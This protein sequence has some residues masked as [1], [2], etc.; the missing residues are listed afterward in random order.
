MADPIDTEALLATVAARLLQVGH[1]E[2]ALAIADGDVE[3]MR[4]YNEGTHVEIGLRVGGAHFDALRASELNEGHWYRD[5]NDHD[6]YDPSVLEGAFIAALPSRVTGVTIIAKMRNVPVDDD[7]RSEFANLVRS[8]PRNQGTVPGVPPAG[9]VGADGLRYR[10]KTEIRLADELL[11][12]GILYMPLGVVARR[13]KGR[14]ERNEPDF[15]IFHG[16]RTGVLEV[17]GAPFH[18]PARAVE[19]EARALPFKLQGVRH[20]MFDSELVYNHPG[21]VIDTFLELLATN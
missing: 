18:P 6:A 17:H 19:E 14:V 2:A 12:R 10:S 11:A 8:S 5:E 21:D 15:V 9:F 20:H 16:G 3:G 7:W 4:P 1:A 13:N